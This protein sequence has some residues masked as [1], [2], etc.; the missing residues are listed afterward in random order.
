MIRKLSLIAISAL[1]L[2]ACKQETIV[3]GER[4]D[5]MADELANAAPVELPPAIAASKTYRCK[6]NSLIY[7]D[8]FNDNL[9]ANLR[10]KSKT[11]TPINLTAPS[12]GAAYA[13]GGYELSGSAEAKSVTLKKG[14]AGQAC[15]G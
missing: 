12:A 2:V 6:D 13:G 4:P 8:W 11:G 15:D 3:A 7:I 1:A 14:G 10:L 5:P 9:T